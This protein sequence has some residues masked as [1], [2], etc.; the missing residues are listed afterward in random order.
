[1]IWGYHYFRKHPIV[2]CWGLFCSLEI[3]AK[4]VLVTLRKRSFKRCHHHQARWTA[5]LN[6]RTFS[7]V[8]YVS[9]PEYY[10]L[11]VAKIFDCQAF[12]GTVSILAN[13]FQRGWNPKMEVWFRWC[14]F[15]LGDFNVQHVN[16]R[17]SEFPGGLAPNNRNLKCTLDIKS[18]HLERRWK[19]YVF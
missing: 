1:M 16:F 19:W 6:W 13:I 12:L 10:W 8:E 11:V 7:K 5:A 17:G 9:S 15:S 2:K 3:H 4:L 14:S 18:Y